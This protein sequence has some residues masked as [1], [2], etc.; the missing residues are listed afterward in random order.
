MYVDA[1]VFPGQGTL[2]PQC[3]HILP[4]PLLIMN[5]LGTMTSKSQHRDV[6]VE[7]SR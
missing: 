7:A 2:N 1:G 5:G 6:S 3:A 4:A